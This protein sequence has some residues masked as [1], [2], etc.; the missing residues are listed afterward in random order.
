ME[1]TLEIFILVG[2]KLLS[3]IV[4]KRE[5]TVSL[6]YFGHLQAIEFVANPSKLDLIPK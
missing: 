2:L 4:Q 5:T 6:F 3:G 1:Y